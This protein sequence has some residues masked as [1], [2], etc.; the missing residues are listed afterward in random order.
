MPPPA[1]FV[2]PASEEAVS[3]HDSSDGES[4]ASF[5][6]SSS[7]EDTAVSGDLSDGDTEDHTDTDSVLVLWDNELSPVSDPSSVV[8]PSDADQYE[9]ESP[10]H[11]CVEIDG[12]P[13]PSPEEDITV[14]AEIA[15]EDD[16]QEALPPTT[17]AVGLS[18]VAV[19]AATDDI[20]LFLTCDGTN[21]VGDESPPLDPSQS[22]LGD[23]ISDAV[24]T[25]VSGQWKRPLSV[26][27]GDEEFEPCAAE[28]VSEPALKKASAPS[29]PPDDS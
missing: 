18:S 27:S 25:E 16:A 19:S 24:M 28:E 6:A 17:S 20:A 3:V 4:D 12:L 5:V 22:I 15:S 9:E 26:G 7:D 23:G 14:V 2:D 1:D 8:A 11:V 13:P 21:A 10:P 29:V